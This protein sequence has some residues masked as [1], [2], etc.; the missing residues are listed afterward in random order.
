MNI[1]RRI[2]TNHFGPIPKDDNGRS[3][4][5][6]HINGDHSDNRIE[7]L[8]LVTIEE[9][10]KIHHESG[11]FIQCLMIQKRMEVSPDERSRIQSEAAKLSNKKRLE[12][13]THNWNSENNRKN[14]LK[15]IEDGRHHFIGESNPVFKQIKDGKNI[16]FDSE[17]QK[18]KGIKSSEYMKEAHKQGKH[19]AQM[20]QTCIHCG[21]T[22]GIGNFKRW[23]GDNCKNKT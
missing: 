16:F 12:E 21:T 17:W 3:L 15:L 8:K 4:E 18:T 1:Y 5:I 22:C 14:A 20:K 7:N 6:H 11:D 19:P 10:Y 2:W 13:G 23:H 9:H